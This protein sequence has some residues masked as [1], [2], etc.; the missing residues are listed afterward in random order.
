MFL[1]DLVEIFAYNL[2]NLGN[3]NVLSFVLI[4]KSVNF[5]AVLMNKLR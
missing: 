1:S 2:D 3:K 4:K 5:V